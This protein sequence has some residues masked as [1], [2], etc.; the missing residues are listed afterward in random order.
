MDRGEFVYYAP[1]FFSTFYAMFA[2]VIILF[3]G[4]LI[5]DIKNEITMW[6]MDSAGQIIHSRIKIESI[7]IT[8]FV[9]VNFMISIYT[10]YL[11]VTPI[12]AD[13][14]LFFALR[15]FEEYFPEQKSF[16]SW[17]YRG[18]YSFIIYVMTVHAYQVIYYTQH[19]K[20]QIMMFLMYASRISDFDEKRN[21]KEL[22][23]DQEYQRQVQ[24]RLKFCIVRYND[25]VVAFSEKQKEIGYLIAGFALC[26]CLLG[27][28]IVLYMFSKKFYPEYYLRMG[29]SS[30]T[31][32]ASFG[33]LI[34]CGQSLESQNDFVLSAANEVSWY[35]FSKNNKTIFKIFLLNIMK[36]RVLRFT[37]NYSMNYKLG[38]T[39][40]YTNE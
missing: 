29:T 11:F 31:A 28:S 4:K 35:N 33:A 24:R 6:T 7:V 16:L 36:P 39:G 38:L 15:F 3:K 2:M 20:F 13:K 27:L 10:V 34:F 32:V 12:F 19:I 8:A 23:Y 21:E 17:T 9:G 25:F 14:E 22:F 30:P 40:T 1:V 18:A 37:E 26:G 5:A